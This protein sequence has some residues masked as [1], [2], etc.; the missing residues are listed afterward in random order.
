VKSGGAMWLC[1]YEWSSISCIV[2]LV[3]LEY[4]WFC[5]SFDG[6]DLKKNYFIKS[7]LVEISLIFIYF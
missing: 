1:G 7:I 4:G 2:Y 3:Y 6:Y 5:C